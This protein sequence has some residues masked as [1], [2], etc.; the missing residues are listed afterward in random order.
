MIVLKVLVNGKLEYIAKNIIYRNY[1]KKKL[2]AY[3]RLR[4]T[5]TGIKAI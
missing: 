1:T 3:F 5:Y 2:R 4:L